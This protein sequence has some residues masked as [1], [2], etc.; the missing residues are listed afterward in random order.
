EDDASRTIFTARIDARAPFG[1][2]FALGTLPLSHVIEPRIAFAAV[3]APNQDDNPLFIPEPARIEP[4]LV[5]RDIRLVTDDPSDRV[6]DARLLQVQLSN[7][8]YGPGRNEAESSRLYGDLRIGS[9]YDWVKDQFTR[10][11]ASADIN[12]SQD[13]SVLL[14]GGW[15]PKAK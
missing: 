11:F 12:P 10:V 5:D 14:D 8:L 2:H 6:P 13:L 9:G 1:R 4:R 3:F 15:D 7:R